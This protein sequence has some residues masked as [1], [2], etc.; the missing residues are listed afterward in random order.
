MFVVA[1][2]V[3]RSSAAAVS[4][5]TA[6]KTAGAAVVRLVGRR[7]GFISSWL[8]FTVSVASLNNPFLEDGQ[9]DHLL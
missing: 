9:D 8:M 7:D 1:S 2:G 5:Q 3:V 6:K 4:R